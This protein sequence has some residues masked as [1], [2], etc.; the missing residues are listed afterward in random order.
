MDAGAGRWGKEA[1]RTRGCGT[2]GA[3]PK[4]SGTGRPGAAIEGAVQDQSRN[5]LK[6]KIKA[7]FAMPYRE[8]R[9]HGVEA[10]V[11]VESA[12]KI[13]QVLATLELIDA[14][15]RERRPTVGGRRSISGIVRT[16]SFRS[17]PRHRLRWLP[18]ATT[19]PGR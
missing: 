14:S 10:G 15:A 8:I 1:D 19:S 9:A 4:D 7:R 18:R 12:M 5:T 6:Y 17:V 16:M 11:H 3:K 2:A 13:D